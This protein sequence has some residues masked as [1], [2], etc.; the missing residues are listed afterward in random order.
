MQSSSNHLLLDVFSQAIKLLVLLCQSSK[1]IA[2]DLV[3][4]EFT[5]QLKQYILAAHDPEQPPPNR[6]E[7]CKTQF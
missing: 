5:T 3:E 7:T 6:Y 2:L 1:E 4:S